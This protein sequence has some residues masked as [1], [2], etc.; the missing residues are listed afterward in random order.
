[1]AN[2]HSKLRHFPNQKLT[3]VQ[4]TTPKHPKIAHGVA[5]TMLGANLLYHATEALHIEPI[6]LITTVAIIALMV[7]GIAVHASMGE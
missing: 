1:M 7:I 5:K 6:H 3:T 4:K 2:K